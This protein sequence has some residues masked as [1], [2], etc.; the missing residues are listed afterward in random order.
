MPMRYAVVHDRVDIADWRVHE[1]D[2]QAPRDGR[3]RLSQNHRDRFIVV[4]PIEFAPVD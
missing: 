1:S 3:L 2:W 4:S